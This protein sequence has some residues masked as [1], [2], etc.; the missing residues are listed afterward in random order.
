M[1]SKISM[2]LEMME[3]FGQLNTT[4]ESILIGAQVCDHVKLISN[5]LV[6]TSSHLMTSSQWKSQ[7]SI[8]L[9][10]KM[11]LLNS[12]TSHR[13]THIQ[14]SAFTDFSIMHLHIHHIF[15]IYYKPHFTFPFLSKC[16]IIYTSHSARR[17]DWRI[18]ALSIS[19]TMGKF[20]KNANFPTRPEVISYC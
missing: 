13:Y 8:W 14:W 20:E 1:W 12:L 11:N 7:K 18:R 15:G 16:Y 10:S 3:T 5:H 9:V 19:S 6:L 17:C 4:S 2:L